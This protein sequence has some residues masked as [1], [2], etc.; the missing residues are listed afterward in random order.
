[1]NICIQNRAEF[2][3]KKCKFTSLDATRIRQSDISFALTVIFHAL[4]PPQPRPT[5]GSSKNVTSSAEA[6]SGSLSVQG[7]GDVKIRT[8]PTLCQVAFL[9][10][11]I[12]MTCFSQQRTLDWPRVARCVRDI[13]DWRDRGSAFWNFL[14]FVAT[15]RGPLFAHILP[16]MWI[17]VKSCNPLSITIL[18]IKFE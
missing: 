4:N 15:Q 13:G 6:R 2:F 7:S 8:R 9:G 16:L 11:K 3:Y 12:L 14:A 17:K 18:K 5:T 10:L 1:M